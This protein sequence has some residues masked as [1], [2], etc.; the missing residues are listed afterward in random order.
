MDVWL[1]AL[2]IFLAYLLGSI[3]SSYI[4]LRLVRGVDI[5]TVGT[6]NA[7]ALNTYQ[8]L[9]APAA[10]AVLAADVSKG[11]PA[12]LLPTWI[13]A[14]NW[15]SYCSAGAVVMG[16]NWPVF[17]NFRGG[18]G[19]ATIVGVGLALAPLL[20]AISLL[21]VVMIVL[22]IRNVVVAAAFG[23]VL[24]NILTV[25]TGEPLT[26]V[27]VCIALTVGVTS[28]YLPNSFRQISNAIRQ[29]RWRNMVFPE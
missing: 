27:A 19:A 26:L 14:P 17:L 29:R 23:F 13:G 24:F 1:A 16:H 18:K 15:A 12:V 6:G 2:S 8:Q 10:L 22:G 7:G 11:V 28:N 4:L 3:P 5:R 20:V 9:G 21:P 25:A